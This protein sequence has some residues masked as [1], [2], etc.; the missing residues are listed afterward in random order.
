VQF[1][2][3]HSK[4]YLWDQLDG[5]LYADEKHRPPALIQAGN[6]A[7]VVSKRVGVAVAVEL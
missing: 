4:H 5:P 6:A 7:V 1:S 3:P 2:K